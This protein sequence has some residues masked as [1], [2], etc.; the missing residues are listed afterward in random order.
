MRSE[1]E[2]LGQNGEPGGSLPEGSDPR[3]VAPRTFIEEARRAQLVDAAIGVLAEHGYEAAS[4][5]RIAQAA[6]VSKGVVSYH[7]DGKDDLLREVV[8]RVR[9]DAEAFMTPSIAA[10]TT[11]RQR[12]GAY[13]R[14]NLAFVD[15]RPDAIAALVEVVGHT[16]PP[17]PYAAANR[18][19]VDELAAGLAA[20]QQAGELGRFDPVVVAL[21]LR[22]AIDAVVSRLGVDPE[23][24]LAASGEE[25]VRL[26]TR[27]VTEP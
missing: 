21:S 1:S 4:L 15:E 16:P 2:V 18:R 14:A 17:N 23:L 24:D 3:S 27:A 19:A 25:L 22:G 6:G 9:T 7:F 11:S 20:G 26:F 10:A 8:E 13:I 5:A 12:L